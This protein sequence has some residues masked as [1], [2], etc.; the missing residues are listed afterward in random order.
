MSNWAITSGNTGLT[1]TS[2]SIDST[3]TKATLSFIGTAQQGDLSMVADEAAL[4]GGVVDESTKIIINIKE[5]PVIVAVNDLIDEMESGKYTTA[6][7]AAAQLVV[8]TVNEAIT[9]GT[10]EQE[11]TDL[12][13]AIA[14]A[15]ATLVLMNQVS[16]SVAPNTILGDDRTVTFRIS[17]DYL[18]DVDVMDG[19][20][21]INDSKFEITNIESL[22][23]GENFIFTK[24]L[25]YLDDGTSAYFSL[26]QVGGFD[27]A[28]KIDVVDITI[29]LKDGESASSL[30]SVLDSIGMY[31]GYVDQD[32]VHRDA[33]VPFV[34]INGQSQT[35][36]W[37]PSDV[38]GDFNG[39]ELVSGADLA[40]AMTYFGAKIDD[41]NWYTSGA[42]RLDFNNDHVV[43]IAD[44]TISAFLAAN[45]DV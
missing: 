17:V 35:N 25:D 4:E 41:A 22:Y 2:V 31:I 16:L 13:A 15:K 5:N 1:L 28:A 30:E 37:I 29:K 45:L 21:K 32:G 11:K 27:D 18:Q 3:N 44:L 40:I 6:S 42:W 14:G 12:L 19:L 26:A 39:D 10:S 33:S 23:E 7:V 34:L 38:I 9:D 43:D 8:D 24:N 36:I 20:I